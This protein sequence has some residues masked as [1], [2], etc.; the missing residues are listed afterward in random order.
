[1]DIAHMCCLLHKVFAEKTLQEE[2]DQIILA[3]TQLVM[4]R[5]KATYSRV[6]KIT[7]KS[8]KMNNIG[9]CTIEDQYKAEEKYTIQ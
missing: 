4:N 7:N 5:H 2:K 8:R 3:A 1:M 9:H 6:P